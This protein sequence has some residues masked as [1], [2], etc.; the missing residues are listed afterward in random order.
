MA[1]LPWYLFIVLFLKIIF[2]LPRFIRNHLKESLENFFY[3]EIVDF[4]QGNHLVFTLCCLLNFYN[5]DINNW[6]FNTVFCIFLAICCIITPL[7]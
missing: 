5:A 1:S 3:N 4:F 7:W 2:R 6:N